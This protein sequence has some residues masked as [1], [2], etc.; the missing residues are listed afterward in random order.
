NLIISDADDNIVLAGTGLKLF[1][2]EPKTGKPQWEYPHLYAGGSLFKGVVI[3]NPVAG[4]LAALDAA[5]GNVIWQFNG[6]PVVAWSD[7]GSLFIL[8]INGLREYALDRS[9]IQ[10][11]TNKEAMTELASVLLSKGDLDEAAKF[12]DRVAKESDPN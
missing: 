6:T 3:A 5:T 4:Q 8:E 12:A 7:G 2:F 10:G 1:A 9:A 11:T